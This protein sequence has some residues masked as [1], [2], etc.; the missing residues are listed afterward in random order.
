MDTG[1]SIQGGPA[2][3]PPR[4]AGMSHALA[5]NWWA[6]AL[7]GVAAVMFGLAAFLLPLV[8]VQALVLLFAAYMIVDGVF[9]I[10]AGVR[11]AARHDRWGLLI[12]EGVAN[13]VAGGL[14]FM[15]PGLTAL[16]FVTLLGVWAVV[17]GVLAVVAAFRLHGTHGRW[18]MA[19][20]G[21]VSVAWGAMLFFAPIAGAVALAW[22]LGAYALAFGALLLALAVRLR[23]HR[24][25]PAAASV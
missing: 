13:L 19:L 24:H 12:L 14:A 25:G 9:A 16:V 17:S 22:W 8:T 20:A 10:T 23:T 5:R 2:P 15:L 18:W 7:R 4:L 1:V 6:L 3:L 21:L 11:A